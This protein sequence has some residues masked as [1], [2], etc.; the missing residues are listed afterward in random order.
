MGHYFILLIFLVKW[1]ITK[2]HALKQII[3]HAMSMSGAKIS[4][5]KCAH[6]LYMLKKIVMI[7]LFD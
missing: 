5:C 7:C 1:K 6:S 3:E 4:T 2:F